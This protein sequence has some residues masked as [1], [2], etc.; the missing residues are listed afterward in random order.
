MTERSGLNPVAIEKFTFVDIQG[1]SGKEHTNAAVG[2]T[3]LFTHMY[4][5]CLSLLLKGQIYWLTEV[6]GVVSLRL[7]FYAI[8]RCIRKEKCS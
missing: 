1:S 5:I 8:T 2:V 6:L 3:T 7:L 4:D